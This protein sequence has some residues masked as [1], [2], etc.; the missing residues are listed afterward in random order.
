M[1]ACGR[2]LCAPHAAAAHDVLPLLC[3]A[4]SACAPLTRAPLFN[5]TACCS[6][7]VEAMEEELAGIVGINPLLWAIVIVS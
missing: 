3:S 4:C 7:L 1:A 6:F 2:P 5:H